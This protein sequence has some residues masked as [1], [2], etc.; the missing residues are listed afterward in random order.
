MGQRNGRR[1]AVSARSSIKRSNA[2]RAAI[3]SRNPEGS[4]LRGLW[5][6]PAFLQK[7]GKPEF[8]NS[9]RQ[10]AI[11]GLPRSW[12]AVPGGLQARSQGQ[13]ARRGGQGHSGSDARAA[14][15]R[16]STTPTRVRPAS[17]RAA[18]EDRRKEL[19]KR[20]GLPVHLKDIHL[21]RGMHCIDCHFKQDAH[22]DGKLYG[23]P[24]NA[25]EITCV[26]CHGTVASYG[27]LVTSGPGARRLPGKEPGSVLRG[28]NLTAGVE[29]A[30][31]PFGTDRF[32][33]AGDAIF[34]RS[35]VT[36]GLEWEVPQIKDSVD[37]TNARRYNPKSYNAKL[38]L[39]H[40]PG[41]SDLV[42]ATVPEKQG[43]KFAHGES[44]MTCQSCHSAWITSCFGCHLSQTANQKKPMLHNEGTVTRNWT[45][46][47]FQV[48]RDDVYMLG[49]DGSVI[50]GKTS[51]V[52]SSSAVVVSSQDLNR[53]WIYFQQQTVSAEG[54]AGQ[55]FNTH[56]PHTVR[57]METK[58]CT[59]CH[60][61]DRGDNNA[62]MSQLLLLGTNFVNFMGRFVFVATGTGGVEAVA[63]TEMEEPQAVIGSDLHRLA[64]PKEFAAH[65]KRQRELTTVRTPQ[66]VER[67][68]RAGARRVRLYR[69]RQGRLQGL[70]RR[71]TQSEGLLREDR[72]ARRYRPWARTPT[73][74]RARRWRSPRRPRWRSIRCGNS[75]RSTRS[76][77]FSPVYRLHLHRGSSGRAC[78][79]DGSH[80]ARR[81][82]DQQLP[83]ARRD[84][85]PEWATE[86]RREP[87]RR[88][89]LR[90]HAGGPRA[91]GR[92]HQ[93][94][95]D[96]EGGWRSRRARDSPAEVSGR[97]SS[98][99]RS[100]PTP[101]A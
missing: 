95:A 33:K 63:V 1:S 16:Q 10:T 46:Y 77:R 18:L 37:P 65:A 72:V 48:L 44:R 94:T 39:Q 43:D 5:S 79:V 92:G 24:R 9:L 88:G 54:Y 31:T 73:S 14:H 28:R 75:C 2:E 22:G 58:T 98:G 30:R 89:Q 56:A 19:E 55:A 69:R 3:E 29:V 57:T 68:R 66:L 25:I 35:M 101:T 83:Q 4:A 32:T 85:Q 74:A 84:L 87:R 12:L 91:R 41:V 60:L 21:E 59:D 20:T 23:E 49:K 99:T 62:I 26:D 67:A 96:A 17:V 70:R 7:T 50:G 86:R 61:S 53:Q 97:F 64:Y 13:S 82:P 81:K 47:N 93:L 8:N 45:S 6:D 27:T 100:S 34:Q 11:R 38:V 80:A 51:P 52:R 71:A 40:E 78:A 42:R 36:P 15:R 76:S 90:L